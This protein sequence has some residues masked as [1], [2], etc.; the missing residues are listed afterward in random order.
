MQE[1]MISHLFD[2]EHNGPV[3]DIHVQIIGKCHSNDKK[4][5]HF[6]LKYSMQRIHM[7]SILVKKKLAGIIN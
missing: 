3:D 1:K 4:E 6:G 5:K 7:D 2:F